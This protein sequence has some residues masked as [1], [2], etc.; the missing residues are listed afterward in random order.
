[1]EIDRVPKLHRQSVRMKDF[2]YAMDVRWFVTVCT[3][4]RRCTLGEIA[5]GEEMPEVKLSEVGKIVEECWLEI[6]DHFSNVMLDEFVIMPNHIHG[7]LEIIDTSHISDT[8]DDNNPA[9][10]GRGVACYA[11]TGSEERFSAISSKPQSLGTIIRSFKSAV[12]KR[13]NE[14]HGKS[15]EPF[16]QRNFYEHGIRSD[17]SLEK[18][19]N[20]IREN[21]LMWNED[22][23]NPANAAKTTGDH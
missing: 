19:Q 6:P 9:T 15:D 11:P 22:E 14:L 20:Y 16:W 12:T 3:H 10:N 1:M 4:E 5:E 18:I 23:D 17:K 8:P 13:I 7:L 21:P 2:D